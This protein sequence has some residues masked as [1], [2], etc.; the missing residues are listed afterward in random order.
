MQILTI[1]LLALAAVQT[2]VTSLRTAIYVLLVQSVLVA[3]A[4][5]VVALETRELHTYIAALL[6]AVIKAGVI[7]FALFRLS[8]RLKR[9]KEQHP[10]LGPNAASLSACV[11]IFFAYS[12]IDHALPGVVSRDALAAAITLV[13]IGLLLMMTR[14]QA[15]LQT[16]GLITMENGIYLVGLSVTQGLPLIIEMGI[17]LDVLVAVLVLVIL[18]YRLKLSFAST[19]TSVL[20]ELKG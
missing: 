6:T 3:G 15:I 5:L 16:V 18:T 13:F 9:E 7:P 4:C 17:F 11:A 2:R 1:L 12:L 10:I 19:D 8:G 14:H 20:E